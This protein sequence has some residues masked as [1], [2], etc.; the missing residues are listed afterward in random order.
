MHGPVSITGLKSYLMP[1]SLHLC[2]CHSFVV[3]VLAGEPQGLTT[4]LLNVTLV[5]EQV[6]P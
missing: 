1:G 4:P 2:R 3:L 5:N 6:I